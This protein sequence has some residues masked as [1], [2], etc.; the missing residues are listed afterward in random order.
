MIRTGVRVRLLVGRTLLAPAPKSI[1]DAIQ[2]IEIKSRERGDGFQ[3]QLGA[4]KERSADFTV[5]AGGLLD[6][7]ARVV[8]V[9][10]LG[11]V[12]EV[13]C[14]GVVLHY[15]LTASD[16]PGRSTF[17]VSGED[18][19][20][21]MG[22]GDPP[23][24]HPNQSDS[25]IVTKLL[26]GYAS[27]GIVPMVTS[28]AN[29]P[30]QTSRIP[31]QRES[32]L[33]YIRRLASKNKFVFYTEPTSAPGTS[34]AYWGPQKRATALQPT[35]TVGLG[36]AAN[37]EGGL[38]FTFDALE[39][40]SVSASTIDLSSKQVVQV[41]SRPEAA[42]QLAARPFEPLR[43]EWSSACAQLDAGD[44]ADRASGMAARGRDPFTVSGEVDALRY[45]GVLRA[46]RLV[47]VRGAGT[48]FDGTYRVTE[49]TYSLR[50]GQFRQRFTLA[51]DGWGPTSPTV[52]P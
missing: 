8:V 39:S 38:H 6:P 31:S 37:V 40:S 2:S 41:R 26:G 45:G 36:A 15:Q 19:G 42:G 28:T 9:V 32:N 12:Q 52:R 24:T 51:R 43:K 5:R 7:P 13:I 18:I 47:A 30:D 44:A 21:I 4:S 23:A 27:Y 20:A 35:L 14:D 22:F 11:L 49:V 33:A 34:N 16:M 50:R 46:R 25:T 48:E 17:S 1:I 10:E 3:I 29:V